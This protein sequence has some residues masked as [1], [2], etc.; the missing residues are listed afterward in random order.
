M[1]IHV[2]SR[3]INQEHTRRAREGNGTLKTRREEKIRHTDFSNRCCLIKIKK[4]NS[5]V[6][7]A[8]DV[9]GT[10]NKKTRMN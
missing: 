7:K 8:K 9:P 2:E 4:E 3:Y 10:R 5:I 6:L 1:F